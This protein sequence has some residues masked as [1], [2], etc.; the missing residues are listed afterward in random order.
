LTPTEETVS[1]RVQMSVVT[2]VLSQA[3]THRLIDVVTF[4]MVSGF[5][6]DL[7]NAVHGVIEATV[8]SRVVCLLEKHKMF[9]YVRTHFSY[10]A[11]KHD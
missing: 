1:E 2:L 9:G 6:I 4:L 11:C 3:D 10:W 7:I 8:E 5:E